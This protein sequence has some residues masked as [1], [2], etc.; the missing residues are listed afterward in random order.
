[1][2]LLFWFGIFAFGVISGAWLGRASIRKNSIFGDYYLDPEEH[3]IVMH[4]DENQV[5]E[6]KRYIVLRKRQSR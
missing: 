6:N 4:M 5:I 1:M 2:E 3:N